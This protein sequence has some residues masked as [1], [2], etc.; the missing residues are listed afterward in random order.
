MF[1]LIMDGGDFSV[2]TELQ[3]GRYYEFGDF[4]TYVLT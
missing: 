1:I 2:N 3:Y 4:S